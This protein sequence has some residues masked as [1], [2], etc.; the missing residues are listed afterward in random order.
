MGTLVGAQL[1]EAYKNIFIKDPSDLKTYTGDGQATNLTIHYTGQIASGYGTTVWSDVTIPIHNDP[2][3]SGSLAVGAGFAAISSLYP[4]IS[5]L[6]SSASLPNSPLARVVLGTIG[7][8]ALKAGDPTTYANYRSYLVLSKSMSSASDNVT[9]A[10]QDNA[11]GLNGSTLLHVLSPVAG[12][13][14]SLKLFNT[15]S[16]GVCL[17]SNNLFYPTGPSASVNL[18]AATSK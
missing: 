17:E 12:G 9:L 6:S 11:D 1:S 8:A 3:R 5:A 18:G 2:N 7:A 13:T 15:A 14:H 4:T 16:G 10:L